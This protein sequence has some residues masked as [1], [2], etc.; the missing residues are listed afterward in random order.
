MYELIKLTNITKK[1]LLKNTSIEILH[2]VN[3]TVNKGDFIV[4]TGRSGSGKSTLLNILGLIDDYNEGQYLFMGND[5]SY[6]RD[7]KKAI[8]RNKEVGFIFQQFNLINDF[9][10][11]QNVELALKYNKNIYWKK[12][13][14][15]IIEKLAEV[16]MLE[17]MNY[18]PY[19]LSG[20]QQQRVAIARALVN[21]P[22]I[23]LADEPTGSLDYKNGNDI[24]SLLTKLKKTVIMVTHNEN[25]CSYASKRIIMDDGYLYS[26]KN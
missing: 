9:T 5:I 16:N 3:L 26:V 8:F 10:V 11:Y 15:I 6:M 17:K 23:I 24:M 7:N 12:R 20:G 14:E 25:Y 18:Y 4:V 19:E 22:N 13:K 1:Y 2:N 21:E